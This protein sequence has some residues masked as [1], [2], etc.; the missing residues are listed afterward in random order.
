MSL[1]EKD[2]FSFAEEL[3]SV[4]RAKKSDDEDYYKKFVSLSKEELQ[5]LIDLLIEEIEDIK[6]INKLIRLKES[7]STIFDLKLLYNN[8]KLIILSTY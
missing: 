3:I 4:W 8:L 5:T 6:G 1:T 7:L 2:L